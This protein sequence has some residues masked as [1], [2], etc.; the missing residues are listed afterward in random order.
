[1]S[2]DLQSHGRGRA[3]LAH[4]TASARG[5]LRYTPTGSARLLDGTMHT[6]RAA[7][8]HD[9]TAIAEIYN[10]GIE[11][12]SST[13]ETT[14][15]TAA[16]VVRWFDGVHPVVVA[17]RAG[18]IVA[19]A[20]TFLYSPRACYATIA[21]FSVYVRRDARGAGAGRAAMVALLDAAEGRGFTK[22]ISRVFIDNAAS[23]HLLTSLGFREVGVYE[24][25]GRLDGVWHDVVIVERLFPANM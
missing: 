8:P 25:H 2:S 19:F 3:I 13:F 6:T 4:F 23:R 20:T 1:M 16:D 15:R 21:E 14:P 17:E 18:G 9:A 24:K 12:R 10:Q 5:D 22:L 11:D 7:T